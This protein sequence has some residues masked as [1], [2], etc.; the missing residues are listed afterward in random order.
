MTKY[1]TRLPGRIHHALALFTPAVLFA[2]ATAAQPASAPPEPAALGSAFSISPLR[3]EITQSG[4]T[5]LF[6]VRNQSN[7]EMALQARTFAWSQPEGADHYEQSADFAISPSI[8]KIKPGQVQNFRVVKLAKTPEGVEATYRVVIDQ[9]PSQPDGADTGA[10]TRL[11]LTV[12]LFIG[13]EKVS[14][15]KLNWTAEPSIVAA[16]NEGART[17]KIMRA[18]LVLAD[19]SSFQLGNGGSRYVLPHAKISWPVPGELGCIKPG[20]TISGI[21]D[22]KPFRAP[23]ASTC[24]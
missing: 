3:I 17:A 4:D 21:I 22:K 6:Q 19:G 20:A 13:S 1:I 2:S 8:S 7:S 11:R 16:A 9:L 10:F 23:I 24:E 14:A 5:A 18:S 12:P 15:S